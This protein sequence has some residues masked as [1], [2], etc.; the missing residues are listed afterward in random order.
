[1]LYWRHRGHLVKPLK[2]ILSLICFPGN[3]ITSHLKSQALH[4]MW[5][6][7]EIN[8]CKAYC[9]LLLINNSIMFKDIWFFTFLLLSNS[10]CWCFNIQTFV[11]NEFILIIVILKE[12]FNVVVLSCSYI[13]EEN[14]IKT[15]H[16][17]P[18]VD[19][20]NY[21]EFQHWFVK[22]FPTEY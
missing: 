20:V 3:R 7:W 18:K 19:L 6:W 17:L 11:L 14:M 10:Y 4:S 1:M 22:L 13:F 5:Y 2:N 8:S 21:I 15:K 16:W 9:W 12:F